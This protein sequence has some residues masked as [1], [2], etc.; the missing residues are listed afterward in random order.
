V[1]GTDIVYHGRVPDVGPFYQRAHGLVVPVFEGSGT[2]LKVVEA[3]LLGR[4]VISTALGAEGLPVRP[5]EH[6]AR[7]ETADEWVAA[8]ERLRR[9]E[10]AGMPDAARAQLH[11]FTWP[12]IAAALARTYREMTAAQMTSTR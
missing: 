10:L 1:P 12:R 4:P 9:G 2:R 11:D 8:V 7:A 3:S 5:D 6:Y